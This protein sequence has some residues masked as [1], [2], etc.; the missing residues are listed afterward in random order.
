MVAKI[1]TPGDEAASIAEEFRKEVGDMLK[2]VALE[3]DCD[4]NEL[5]FT[6]NSLGIVNIQSMDPEEI[7]LREAERDKQKMR[8]IILD[9][10]SIIT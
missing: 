4:V 6:V 7:R 5:K 1:W 9:R 10:K 2:K 8:K 3:N